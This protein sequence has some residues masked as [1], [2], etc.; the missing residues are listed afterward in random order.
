MA[1]ESLKIFVS[2]SHHDVDWQRKITA[3]LKLLGIDVWEDR[4]IKPGDMWQ[5]EIEEALAV[6]DIIL[7]LISR[8]FLSSTFVTTEELPAALRRVQTEQH[9]PKIIPVLLRETTWTKIFGLEG[10]HAIPRFERWIANIGSAENYWPNEDAAIRAVAKELEEVVA[11]VLREKAQRSVA[12]AD[13]R[14][15]VA[16]ALA[17]DDVISP[18][19]RRTLEEER[20]RLGLS[21]NVAG[22]VEATEIGLHA[23]EVEKIRAYEADLEFAIRD[24]G[25][26]FDEQTREELKKR[27]AKLGLKDED[28]VGLEEKVAARL[29]AADPAPEAPESTLAQEGPATSSHKVRPILEWSVGARVFARWDDASYYPGT[30]TASQG[31]G[32]VVRFDDG[33]SSIVVGGEMAPVG[34]EVGSRVDARWAGDDRYYPARVDRQEGESVEVT[35]DDGVEESMTISELRL[36]RL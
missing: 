34:L 35:F 3:E 23:A 24:V 11:E 29:T 33:T 5:G 21:E 12:E 32:Y 22:V 28:V 18:Y 26:P 30:I 1:D 7:L 14:L 6:A 8:D 10:I 16:E 17:D 13:Y 36:G 31:D 15:R 25:V 27:K 9:P 19:E 20:S 4:Q 2:Y